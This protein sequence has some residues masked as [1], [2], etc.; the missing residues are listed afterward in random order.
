MSFYLKYKGKVFEFHDVDGDG[1]CLHNSLSLSAVIDGNTGPEVIFD[2]IYR[3]F[4]LILYLLILLK[5]RRNLMK[6]LRQDISGE[7]GR[8]REIYDR[9]GNEDTI[10]DW[11]AAHERPGTWGGYIVSVMFSYIYDINIETIS[12][13]PGGFTQSATF[14]FLNYL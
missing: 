3:I 11:I 5:A 10:E 12:N 13:L 8:A 7:N 4:A 6:A 2:M 1:N 14:V 9:F